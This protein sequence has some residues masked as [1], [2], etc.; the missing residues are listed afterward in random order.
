VENKTEDKSSWGL[1][2]RI[3][4]QIIRY[5]INSLLTDLILSAQLP[6]HEHRRSFLGFAKL[7]PTLDP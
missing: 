3:L 6:A 2:G 7:S 1:V 4:L 5:P